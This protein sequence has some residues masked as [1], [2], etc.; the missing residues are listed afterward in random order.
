LEPAN[1]LKVLIGGEKDQ[2]VLASH[3]RNEQV[4]LRQHPAGG[5]KLAKNLSKLRGGVFI[6]GPEAE[7]SQSRLKTRQVLPVAAAHPNAGPLLAV[8]GQTNSEAVAAS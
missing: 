1:R 5:A 8:N 3:G 6:G 4:E 7:Y 2:L